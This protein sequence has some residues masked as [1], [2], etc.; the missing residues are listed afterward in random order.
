MGLIASSEVFKKVTKGGDIYYYR[1]YTDDYMYMMA[2][3][4][5]DDPTLILDLIKRFEFESETIRKSFETVI[6][7]FYPEVRWRNSDNPSEL[8]NLLPG[9]HKEVKHPVTGAEGKLMSIIIDLN[10]LAQVDKGR[11]WTREE[12]ADW[13]ESAMDLEDITFK[14]KE[15]DEARSLSETTSLAKIPRL[16]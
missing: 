2:F 3:N 13:I 10:D 12:I 16:L 9:V 8:S 6:R 11:C 4:H 7:N 5:L 15:Q 14:P 1:V